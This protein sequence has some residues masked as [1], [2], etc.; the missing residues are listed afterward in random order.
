MEQLR[1][2]EKAL[3]EVRGV[4]QAIKRAGV[5]GQFLQGLA[6]VIPPGQG[7]DE[8]PQVIRGQPGATVRDDQSG[9]PPRFVV[10]SRHT[11]PSAKTSFFQT[12]ST[13]LRRSIP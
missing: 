11:S 13:A 4:E 2:L 10:F 12:G 8:K 7:V 1:S 5:S 9:S 6:I 3:K